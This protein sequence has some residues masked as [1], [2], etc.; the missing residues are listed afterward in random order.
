VAVATNPNNPIIA[1]L[2][3][4]ILLIVQQIMLNYLGPKLMGKAFKLHPIIVL[5]SF[6]VGYKIAGAF[7]A[8]FIVPILAILVIV[9]KELEHY[10]VN[11]H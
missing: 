3:F 4:A 8:I 6:I 11:P 7:G 2:I 9:F 10:F 1:V 5:L